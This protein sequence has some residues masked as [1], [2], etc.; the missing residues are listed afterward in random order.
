MLLGCLVKRH[1]DMVINRSPFIIRIR[2]CKMK[3][4]KNEKSYKVP[5]KS[6]CEQIE[7]GALNQA[8]NLAKH[9]EVHHHVA[10][11]PDCHLGYGMPIGGVIAC[12]NAVIP[13]AVGVDIGCGMGAVKTDII[14]KKVRQRQLQ[15]LVRKIKELIPCGEGKAHKKQQDW[16]GFPE[17]L[18]NY[19]DRKWLTNH[20]K[21]LAHR[22]LGT[23]G[24]GNHFIEIQA[25]D[26]GFIWLMIHTG[27]RHL[28]NVIARYY[29]DVAKDLNSKMK[30]HLPDSNLAFLPATSSE[31]K[32]YIKDMNLALQYAKE[33]RR[34]IMDQFK[35]AFETVFSNTSFEPAINI[36]HNY[37]ALESHFG[38][39]VWIHRKGATSAQKGEIGII[40][41]SMG[42]PSY[43]VK[44]LGNP[45][46][47]Y[48]CSHGAGR[49]MGRRNASRSLSVKECD[50]AMTGIL[51]DDWHKIK[52]GKEK[53][54]RDLGE[55]PQA[56]KNIEHVI[57]AESDL[58]EPMVK[59]RPLAVV[60]G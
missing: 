47:F 21:E 52:R 55:A 3:W 56:Y 51:Y 17:T 16:K 32:N 1:L 48:S 35:T 22:N 57:K 59:L 25:D 27:S 60:K 5:I 36:H 53:G 29:N 9:P 41:G 12:E 50:K 11:M 54:N 26:N 6:W 33:N 43:I 24:G 18:E 38:K 28:G 2:V 46:S 34:R 15:T 58:I 30:K 8:I 37:A 19:S 44:G 45:D 23:L 31:G 10:L 14:L 40:P 49:V 39:K 20:A 42:T 13:N 7:E 4:V